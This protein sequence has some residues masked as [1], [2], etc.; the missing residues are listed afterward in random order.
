MGGALV[1]HVAL[2]LGLLPSWSFSKYPD[3]VR[4]LLAGRMTAEQA[5]DFS[6][7]YLLANL[8]FPPLALRWAQSFLGAAVAF[9]AWVL[10]SRLSGRLA[11]GV[12]LVL[13]SLGTPVLVNEATLEPETLILF[14]NSLALVC[15]ERAWSSPG[16]AAPLGAG[17]GLGLSAATRPT[18][19]PFLF[20]ASLLLGLR[21]LRAE[22][23]ARAVLPAALLLLAGL[24][25][26]FLPP[27]LL[28]TVAGQ[29]LGA[30]M[31]G[32]AVLY[33]GN[34]PE[35]T[36]VGAQGALLLHTLELQER[37][38]DTPDL[39]H[40]LY[41]RF[42]R[43]EV[44]PSLTPEGSERYWTSKV[45]AFARVHPGAFA[46]QLFRKLQFFLFGPD[47]HDVADTRRAEVRLQ[48]LPLFSARLFAALGFA[49][50]L[51]LA[52]ARR[53][54]W[55]LLAYW[56][57]FALV[58]VAFQV[59][60]RYR[61]P[62]VVLA[63]VLGAVLVAELVRKVWLRRGAFFPA[64]LLGLVA[65]LALTNGTVRNGSRMLERAQALSALT[66]ALEEARAR[67]RLG[68]A[69][70]LF[71][72]AQ[73]AQPFLTLTRNLRGLAFESF[74][75]AK[76][77]GQASLLRFGTATQADGFVLAILAARAG[78]CEEA[79]SALAEVGAFR[80]S[81]Y[82]FALDPHLAAADCL[83]E[84]GRKEGA[85][86]EVRQSL[87]ERPGTVEGLARAVALA[88]V[89]PAQDGTQGAAWEQELFALHNVLNAR[90]AL[91][92]AKNAAGDFAGALA[93]AQAAGV[94][95]PEAALLH[96]E[97]AVALAGLGRL[98]EAVSAYGE[99]LERF[100]GHA[101]ATRP[102]E[103][104]VRAALAQTPDEPE[105]LEVASEHELRAGRMSA[106]LAL[107]IRAD[108]ARPSASL[109]ERLK[110][111]RSVAE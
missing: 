9:L 30:T 25:C 64:M 23:A 104:A 22:R 88:K 78:H 101:F 73:A 33:L 90:Y 89:L 44:G 72:E 56:A 91:A 79:L 99:A 94:H 5:A 100:P 69:T 36:G 83:V 103:E 32:G 11:G 106:A 86:A 65:V 43:A 51:W 34:R 59:T 29:R 24:L 6:P 18:V 57:N 49:G 71:V 31:A 38:H 87:A 77:S 45:L 13:V 19:L 98:R 14:L 41:R 47:A 63:S 96:Y 21:G 40:E 53:L 4:L 97:R 1:A 76:A 3:G 28:K 81:I 75:V 66:P 68:E 74:E 26:A 35:G 8:A 105:V 17:L 110:F 20:L 27:A 109:A 108:A 92:R 82:D 107:A 102:M 48:G 39:V 15:L 2:G 46:G 93:D 42:A 70:R 7:L 61:H 85:L 80:S 67:G 10:A 111:L 50:L 37:T 16:L 62:T 95:L 84:L 52:W 60:S 58:A 12:A 55:L 54:S